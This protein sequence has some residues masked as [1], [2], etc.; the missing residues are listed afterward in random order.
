M[1][2]VYKIKTWLKGIRVDSIRFLTPRILRAHPCPQHY[3]EESSLEQPHPTGSD[4]VPTSAPVPL[5][6]DQTPTA[7]ADCNDLFILVTVLPKA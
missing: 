3:T 2:A 1:T 7:A 6:C 4:P 5:C